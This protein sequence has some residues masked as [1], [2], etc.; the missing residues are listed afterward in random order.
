MERTHRSTTSSVDCNLRDCFEQHQRKE[1][2]DHQQVDQNEFDSLLIA[3]YYDIDSKPRTKYDLARESYDTPFYD[4]SIE[5][6]DK[7]VCFGS[8]CYKQSAVNYLAQGMYAASAGDTLEGAVDTTNWWNE[9]IWGHPATDEE[10]FWT[11]Y[12]Y[13]YYH[14]QKDSDEHKYK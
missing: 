8:D 9:T 11:K 6:N 10:L 1:F 7:E 12:G 2:T 13:G 14:L 3:I 4:G 5:G